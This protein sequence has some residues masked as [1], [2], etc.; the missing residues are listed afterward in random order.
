MK[1]IIFILSLLV[2]MV[3]A[4][5]IPS[6]PQ[7]TFV[8]D[9]AGIMSANQVYQFNAIAS[10]LAKNA[11]FGLA[12][13][14][15]KSIDG[16]DPVEFSLKVAQKWAICSKDS[17]EGVLIYVVM[18][19]HYR[20]VQVGYGSEGYLPDV[21]V[22]HLQ[23]ASLIPALQQ[24]EGGKGAIKL[25]SMIAQKVQEEKKI[26]LSATLDTAQLAPVKKEESSLTATQSVIAIIAVI[27]ICIVLGIIESVTGIPCLSFLLLILSCFGGKGGGSS[28]GRGGFGGG[29]FGGGGSHGGW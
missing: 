9:G 8:Y 25:A 24:G 10:D 4:I 15:F 18:D 7:N 29:G 23:Q 1:K 17:N 14:T 27:V 12:L 2:S 5:E 21:L 16:Q 26:T 22:E 3:S 20:G 28:G 13:A 19:P 11:H 6:I